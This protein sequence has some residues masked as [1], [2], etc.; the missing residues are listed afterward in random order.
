M[1]IA[2]LLYD[3]P[4]EKLKFTPKA[5]LTQRRDSSETVFKEKGRASLAKLEGRNDGA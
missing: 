4:V 1:K 5:L 3:A 2:S